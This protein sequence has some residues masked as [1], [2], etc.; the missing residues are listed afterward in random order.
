MPYNSEELVL[1]RPSVAVRSSQTPIPGPSEEFFTETFGK[2]LPP[3]KFLNITDGKAAYYELLPSSSG[4]LDT[5]RRVLLIH[6]VQ[7]PALGML[8]LARE[9]QTAFPHAH[10]V[11]VDLWGHGLSDTPIVPHNSELF[12]QLLDALLDQLTW[13][14]AHLVGYSFGGALTAGYVA[15]RPSRVDS[16]TLVAPAGLLLFSEFSAEEQGYLRG[17]DETAARRW[18][19]AW[20]EGG[21]LIVPTDWEKRVENGEVVAEAVREWQMREHLGHTASVVAI[22]RD[23]GVMD[24]HADFTKAAGTGIPALAVLGELDSLCTEQQLN[25]HGFSDVIVVPEIGHSVV[26]DRAREVRVEVAKFWAK[27]EK[28]E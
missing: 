9:L 15:S 27:L 11:L 28:R 14:S 5:P 8:P 25:D 18:V 24:K 10:L 23:G 13:P 4:E 6:G 2:L 20:L 21:D 26:R 3:A 1:P 7:T 16:F 22:V 12:H 17:G 19:V